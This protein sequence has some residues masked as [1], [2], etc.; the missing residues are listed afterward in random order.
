MANLASRVAQRKAAR[1]AKRTGGGARG[2]RI[3]KAAGRNQTQRRKA[4][5]KLGRRQA[6]IL[7]QKKRERRGARRAKARTRQ[8]RRGAAAKGL[9]A[10]LGA[11]AQR[12]AE[13]KAQRQRQRTK[14]QQARQR[15]RTQRARAKAEGGKWSPE[16]TAARWQG[17]SDVTGSVADVASP[18][19]GGLLGGEGGGMGAGSELGGMAE[20]PGFEEPFGDDESF[21][22]AGNGA[23]NWWTDQSMAVQAGIVAAGLAA[24]YMVFG[25]KKKKK[26]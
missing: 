19:V 22:M 21:D 1:K 6:R 5:G 17:I 4:A 12:R 9:G 8:S 23:G 11:A 26:K 7:S 24:A 10:G 25:R 14:R 20:S 3:L 15:G 16:S 2:R 13:R 18:L